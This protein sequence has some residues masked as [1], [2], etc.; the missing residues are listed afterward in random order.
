[1]RFTSLEKSLLWN[2][3]KIVLLWG[4]SLLLLG[5][6]WYVDWLIALFYTIPMLLFFV[7]FYVCIGRWYFPSKG[8]FRRYF[9]R[10]SK[11]ERERLSEEC[12]RTL[13][14]PVVGEVICLDEYL[15]FRKFGMI[16]RYDEIKRISF[17]K[18]PGFRYTPKD[19]F[20]I[21]VQTTDLKAYYFYIYNNREVFQN[22][23]AYHRM[24][25][26]VYTHQNRV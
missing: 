9:F 2:Y 18:W 21:T 25:D 7:F 24:M 13:L 5:L 20:K 3:A 14:Y 6:V 8:Y 23:G 12:E 19:S 4:G 16:L 22:G 17:E 10:H 1:M 11:E 26:W 15:V